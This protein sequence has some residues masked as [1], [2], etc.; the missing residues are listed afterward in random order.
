MA[1][2][3]SIESS[4][5]SSNEESTDPVAVEEQSDSNNYLG[6]FGHFFSSVVLYLLYFDS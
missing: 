4:Q 1:A 5:N 3:M 2:Q 6:K